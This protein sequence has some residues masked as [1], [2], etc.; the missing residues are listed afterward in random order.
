MEVCTPDM[1]N[2][3]AVMEVVVPVSVGVGGVAVAVQTRFSELGP[4]SAAAH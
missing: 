2:G 4:S 3:A 1:R